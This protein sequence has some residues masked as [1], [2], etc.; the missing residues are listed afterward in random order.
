MAKR[1]KLTGRLVDILFKIHKS[2][3]KPGLFLDR[4]IGKYLFYSINKN[5]LDIVN[6]TI[7]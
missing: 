3:I 5:T 6:S 2:W 7:C 1:E 4:P